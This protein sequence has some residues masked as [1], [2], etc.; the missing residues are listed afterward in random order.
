MDERRNETTGFTGSDAWRAWCRVIGLMVAL[1]LVVACGASG[2]EAT[3][4]ESDTSAVTV[5]REFAAAVDAGE[6]EEAFTMLA[7]DV[8]LDCYGEETFVGLAVVRH[9]LCWPGA[10]AGDF[11]TESDDPSSSSSIVS[12][13]VVETSGVVRYENVMEAS[14]TSGVV[15]SLAL[16]YHELEP[17]DPRDDSLPT[18]HEGARL[19]VGH[20]Y[21]YDFWIHCGMDFLGE[22]N[23]NRFALVEAPQG[24]HPRSDWP[25]RPDELLGLVTLVDETRIE[26]SIPSGEVIGVYE[27]SDEE[28]PGCE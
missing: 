2:E 6:F 27:A 16:T 11:T 17:I 25:T 3:A 22:F 20:T 7:D 28:P 9:N 14:I 23:E 4:G 8:T 12:W 18:A 19:E 5:A 1:T 13:R 15:T 21:R 10:D 26:L 24:E